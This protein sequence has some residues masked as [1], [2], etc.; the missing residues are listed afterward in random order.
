MVLRIRPHRATQSKNERN[1]AVIAESVVARKFPSMFGIKAPIEL[2]SKIENS[3]CAFSGWRL[4]GLMLLLSFSCQGIAAQEFDIYHLEHTE[5]GSA[6][7]TLNGF[8]EGEYEDALYVNSTPDNKRTAYLYSI[9]PAESGIE[10]W[11]LVNTWEFDEDVV[12]FDIVKTR[13][14]LRL[15]IVRIDNYYLLD[16][17]TMEETLAISLPSI[18][19]MPAYASL[20]K[21]KLAIDLNDDDLSDLAIPDF[22]GYWIAKQTEAG[23]FENVQKL[24]VKPGLVA[25]A[26]AWSYRPREIYQLDFNGDGL[27]DLCFW[28]RGTF[29]VYHGKED[30]YSTETVKVE[31]GLDLDIDENVIVGF[32]FGGSA[33]SAAQETE[34]EDDGYR[35]RTLE[36]LKKLNDDEVIDAVVLEVEQRGIFDFRTTYAIHFGVIKDGRTT[37]NAEPDTYIGGS[38]TIGIERITDINNDGNADIVTAGAK[39]SIGAIIRFLLTW[40]FSYRTEFY[41]MQDGKFQPEPD[42]TR[43]SKVKVDFSARD[44]QGAN[45]IAI[46]DLNGD[47]RDELVVANWGANELKIYYGIEGPDLFEK[48]PTVVEPGFKVEGDLTIEHLNNDNR[49]DM[50]LERDD[51]ITFIISR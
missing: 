30:G 9:R 3:L 8:T 37:F 29:F 47:D 43:K 14:G 33:A 42:V 26:L 31:L 32:A 23:S 13:E 12:G 39:I 51:G 19:R 15:L 28:D 6:I 27:Q 44:V 16:L 1:R 10:T 36:R 40:S 11:Q 25:G 38:S 2:L 50:M 46:G 17:N 49:E 20:P 7:R 35:S 21:M 24:P 48:N 34:E 22:D 45:Q 4:C 5:E 18:Y 41:I